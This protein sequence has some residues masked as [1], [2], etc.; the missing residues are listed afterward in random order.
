MKTASDST[1]A[2]REE[3]HLVVSKALSFAVV[4]ETRVDDTLGWVRYVTDT[5]VAAA[6][7]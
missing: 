6:V 5:A 7:H 4:E 3:L 2:K 1:T